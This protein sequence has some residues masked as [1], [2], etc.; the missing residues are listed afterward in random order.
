MPRLKRIFPKSVYPS[1]AFNFGPCVWTSKHRDILNCP[2]GWCAIQALGSFNPTTGGHLVLWELKL[3]IEFPPASLVLIPSATVTHSNVPT[4]E[5]ELRASFT[6]YCA[7]GLF[8]YV[9][10]G[11]RKEKD[12]SKKDY[13]EMCRIR[14]SRWETGLSL[15]ST[16]NDYDQ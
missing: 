16:L 14:G 7:G 11:F 9:D 8:R 12:L 6:Q 10:Y 2:F 4:A 3:V 5:G 1:C 13:E 15:L